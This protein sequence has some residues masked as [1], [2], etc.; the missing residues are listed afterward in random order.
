MC[1]KPINLKV[2]LFTDLEGKWETLED[3]PTMSV[4]SKNF[5]KQFFKLKKCCLLSFSEICY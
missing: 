5:L 3:V 1:K 2:K 4:D